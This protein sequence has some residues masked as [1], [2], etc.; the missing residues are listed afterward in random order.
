MVSLFENFHC[1]LKLKNF[2]TKKNKPMKT[3]FKKI[4]KKLAIIRDIFNFKTLSFSL[5]TVD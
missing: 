1:P 3:K 4:I 5:E 2:Q